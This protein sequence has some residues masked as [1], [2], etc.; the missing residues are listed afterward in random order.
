MEEEKE[1]GRGDEERANPGLRPSRVLDEQR[2]LGVL[3]F[4]LG[5]GRVGPHE[6]A[7]QR[8]L[9]LV[10]RFRSEGIMNLVTRK[11]GRRRRLRT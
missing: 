4:L 1:R 2:V 11:A 8:R 10:H 3:G 6:V 7:N 5:V 9:V